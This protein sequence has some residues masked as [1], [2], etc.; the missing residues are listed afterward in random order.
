MVQGEQGALVHLGWLRGCRTPERPWSWQHPCFGVGLWSIHS[1]GTKFPVWESS[2]MQRPG[3]DLLLEHIRV[4]E[5]WYLFLALTNPQTLLSLP[6]RAPCL[7]MPLT[8]GHMV[9]NF[10]YPDPCRRSAFCPEAWGLIALILVCINTV[11]NINP[12]T[13]VLW[14]GFFFL[15]PEGFCSWWI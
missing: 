1:S 3:W 2:S 5:I 11:L 10:L 6:K 14:S 15:P 12:A 7:T 9:R 13:I 4:P 8:M